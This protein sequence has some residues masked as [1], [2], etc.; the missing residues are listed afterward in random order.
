M[1]L[2]NNFI[3]NYKKDLTIPRIIMAIL[4]S[5]IPTLLFSISITS[6]RREIDIFV[7]FCSLLLAIFVTLFTLTDWTIAKLVTTFFLLMSASCSLM[8]PLN[9]LHR[10]VG[11]FLG[12]ETFVY[13][14]LKPLK[15]R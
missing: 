11:I 15:R 3:R 10:L 6:H 14:Y 5:F 1:S 12:I 13:V 4:M 9:E 2:L 8:K 7:V